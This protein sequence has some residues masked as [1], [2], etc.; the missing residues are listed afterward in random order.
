[1]NNEFDKYY[2]IGTYMNEYVYYNPFSKMCKVGES[3]DPFPVEKLKNWRN[4]EW[5]LSQVDRIN[6][7]AGLN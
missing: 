4:P 7:M 6:K 2:A 5:V 3:G 1:M